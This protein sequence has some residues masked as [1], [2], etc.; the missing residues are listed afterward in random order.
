MV[1]P[2]NLNLNKNIYCYENSVYMCDGTWNQLKEDK[3][4]IP[5]FK[6]GEN[7]IEIS[8]I[9]KGKEG[10]YINCEFKTTGEPEMVTAR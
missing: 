5:V 8:G 3:M 10:P 7:K 9:F 2:Y 1:L 6:N 4:N